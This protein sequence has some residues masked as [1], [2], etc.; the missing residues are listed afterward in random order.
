M[1]AN[2]LTLLRFVGVIA[3]LYLAASPLRQ[4]IKKA[5]SLLPSGSRK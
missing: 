5:F 1:V 4:V 2:A 3:A